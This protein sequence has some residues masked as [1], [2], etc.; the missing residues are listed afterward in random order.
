[1]PEIFGLPAH[2]F[3]IHFP[4]VAIPTVTILAFIAVARSSFRERYGLPIFA[5]TVV[6]TVSAILAVWSGQ[7]LSETYTNTDF[8]AQHRSTG[9]ALRLIMIGLSVAIGGL[10]VADRRRDTD[11]GTD[12]LTLLTSVAVLV[13]AILSTIWTIRTGHEGARLRWG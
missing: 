11:G 10:L 6:S 4:I 2:P 9:E 1:M 3:L 5:L 8:L 7:A 13:L 12:P